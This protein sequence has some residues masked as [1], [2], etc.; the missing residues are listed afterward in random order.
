MININRLAKIQLVSGLFLLPILPAQADVSSDFAAGVP[1][2][3]IVLNARADG[4]SLGQ[5][6]RQLLDEG[7]FVD[8]QSGTVTESTLT[9][10]AASD[11][12][13]AS[14]GGPVETL[15]ESS[16]EFQ[17]SCT[18]NGLSSDCIIDQEVFEFEVD[19]M[20]P[21]LARSDVDISA[22][23]SRADDPVTRQRIETVLQL[24][25]GT[26]TDVAR[27]PPATPVGNPNP[28]IG[29]AQSP[30]VVIGL[31]SRNSLNNSD[32]I[33]VRS[34]TSNTDAAGVNT[35]INNIVGTGRPT[36]VLNRVVN[37]GA[38]NGSPAPVTTPQQN[39]WRFGFFNSQGQG[40]NQGAQTII[41]GNSDPCVNSNGGV[42]SCGDPSPS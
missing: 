31:S 1:L 42:G 24:Q 14:E 29:G 30:T 17:I 3:R 34:T 22:L 32:N 28:V 9:E 23:E 8:F 10:I 21:L 33:I 40:T 12:S 37:P 25:N 35:L 15:L 11:T 16:A 20:E 18:A 4:L 7:L 2:E 38:Q 6:Q 13:E 27:Q 39:Q 5:I 41:N 19:S 26:G 36:N